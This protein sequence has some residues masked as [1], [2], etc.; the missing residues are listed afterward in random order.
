MLSL[1]IQFMYLCPICN[2][3]GI[4]VWRKACLGPGL[5]TKCRSC[6]KKVGT[7]YSSLWA[8]IP[9]IVSYFIAHFL[10]QGEMKFLIALI[11]AIVT[12]FLHMK[13]VPLISKE[14]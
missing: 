14:Q 2:K 1:C 13:F 7:A 3:P 11:G 4:P 6:G 12:G 8:F 5:P 10:M 9:F